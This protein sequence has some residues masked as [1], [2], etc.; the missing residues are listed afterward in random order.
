MSVPKGLSEEFRFQTLLVAHVIFPFIVTLVKEILKRLTN[1]PFGLLATWGDAD[2]AYV[3]RYHGLV[4]VTTSSAYFLL[5]ASFALRLSKQ[6]PLYEYLTAE[7]VAQ[8]VLSALSMILWLLFTVWDLRRVRATDVSWKKAIIYITLGAFLV[9]PAGCLTAA[10]TW[11]EGTLER[12]RTRK[13]TREK[14]DVAV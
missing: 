13:A 14:E 8:S 9:G 5:M 10:W 7:A 4:F 11:R 2:I 6:I 1:N 12:S 3:S